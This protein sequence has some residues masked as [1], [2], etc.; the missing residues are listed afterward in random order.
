MVTGSSEADTCASPP[1]PAE[2]KLVAGGMGSRSAPAAAGL[3]RA[4]V[5]RAA[6][7]TPALNGRDL[8][9]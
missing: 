4:D 9:G 2:G 3:V 1:P 8:R 6:S 5:E 7:S